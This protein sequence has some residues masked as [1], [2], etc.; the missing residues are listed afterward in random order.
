MTLLP[1]DGDAE[2]RIVARLRATAAELRALLRDFDPGRWS[3]PDCAALA[4]ELATTAKACAS[5]SALAAARAVEC[6]QGDVEWV[7]RTAGS[8]P[9]E[10]RAVLSTVKAAAECP[11]TSTALASG[12]ISLHQA[13]EIVAAEA[14]VPGSEA[15]LLEVAATSGMAG[16]RAEARRVVLGSMD[17]EALH[18][19]QHRAR[20]VQHWIDGRGMV[21]GRFRLPPEVGVRFVNRLDA[22]T[23]RVRRAA[24]RR[25]SDRVAA[26][27]TRRMR[28]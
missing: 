21:A 7:A 17:R 23:D 6:N 3:G 11:A 2:G 14:A 13:R 4:E 10:A 27:R 5:A 22:V 25:G 19:E 12:Q 15:E 16:L 18:A 20:S 28:W 1:A 26:T 9:G 24:R 8:T